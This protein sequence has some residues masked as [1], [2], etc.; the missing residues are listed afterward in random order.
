MSAIINPVVEIC[1]HREF[2]A[3]VDVNRLTDDVGKLTGFMAHIRVRCRGCGVMMKFLGLPIGCHLDGATVSV[4][5]EELRA[6]IAPHL[7]WIA[8]GKAPEFRGFVARQ[9]PVVDVPVSG[10]IIKA[11]H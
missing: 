9:A 1:E 11:S 3:G 4:G 2:D 10:E 5:A 8:P 6:A 7:D